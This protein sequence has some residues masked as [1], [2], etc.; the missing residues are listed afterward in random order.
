[1]QPFTGSPLPLRFRRDLRQGLPLKA[2]LRV[3]DKEGI[4]DPKS[5]LKMLIFPSKRNTR[6]WCRTCTI[7]WFDWFI[8]ISSY[9]SY[10]V[11]QIISFSSRGICFVIKSPYGTS[12][13]ESRQTAPAFVP[14]NCTPCVTLAQM[15]IEFHRRERKGRR[16]IKKNIN[17]FL[18]HR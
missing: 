7:Y 15:T 16:V 12:P 4:E 9:L 11:C 10:R 2:G 1:M 17:R 14:Q 18:S 5:P 6:R 8:S 13:Q 3:K